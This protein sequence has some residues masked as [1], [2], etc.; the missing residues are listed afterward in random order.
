MTI[1]LHYNYT[2]VHCLPFASLQELHPLATANTPAPNPNSPPDP[3]DESCSD[4]G[5]E[6]NESSA[7]LKQLHPLPTAPTPAPNPNSPPDPLDESYS[8]DGEE[9]NESS[10]GSEPELTEE[11]RRVEEEENA[12][13]LVS[14]LTRHLKVFIYSTS[15]SI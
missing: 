6:V 4:D 3:L 10:S 11:Q 14:F 13:Y 12:H 15:S 7:S 2:S 8:D 5:E 1:L 9:V